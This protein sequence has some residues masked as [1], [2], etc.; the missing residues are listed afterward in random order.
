MT[1]TGRRRSSRVGGKRKCTPSQ[2]A[3]AAADEFDFEKQHQ[4]SWL[5]DE[6]PKK[7]KRK[8]Y[9][10]NRASLDI[11]QLMGGAGGNSERKRGFDDAS[12]TTTSSNTVTPEDESKST[13][14]KKQKYDDGS[15]KKTLFNEND[16]NGIEQT[17][18]KNN[19]DEEEFTM[20]EDAGDDDEEKVP[21][22]VAADAPAADKALTAKD[23]E[24]EYNEEL[25]FPL[26]LYHMLQD[27]PEKGFEYLVSWMPKDSHNGTGFIVHDPKAFMVSHKMSIFV[28]CLSFFAPI[29]Q[30]SKQN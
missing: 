7:K 9:G 14:K 28:Q 19:S 12:R 3:D 20:T 16:E 18:S 10:T 29:T 4:P 24:N 21:P 2:D 11:S 25:S 17:G 1:G 23:A 13:K 15:A 5:K 6:P 30:T 8:V 26:A 22:P 27:A